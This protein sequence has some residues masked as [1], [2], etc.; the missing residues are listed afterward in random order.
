MK[1]SDLKELDKL[2]P[3]DLFITMLIDKNIVESIGLK[4]CQLTW[5]KQHCPEVLHNYNKEIK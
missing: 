1:S 2:V 5:M 4:F 3:N